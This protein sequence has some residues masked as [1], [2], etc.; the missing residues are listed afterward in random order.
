M[1]RSTSLRVSRL[2]LQVLV[3]L[4]ERLHLLEAAHGQLHGRDEVVALERL[5]QVGKAPP[6][7]PVDELPLAESRQDQHR[8]QAVG[9]YLGSGRKPVPPGILMSRMARS[10]RC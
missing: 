6:S 1:A 5:D 10:G 7:G 2:F 8:C 4:L 9:R 3:L